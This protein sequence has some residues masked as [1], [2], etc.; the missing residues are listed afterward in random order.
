MNEF[1]MFYFKKY[2]TDASYFKI[3]D[4]FIFILSGW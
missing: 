2:T 4:K 1:L 3:I